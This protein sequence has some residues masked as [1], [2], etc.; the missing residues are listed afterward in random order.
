MITIQM[1][2]HIVVA[3]FSIFVF[4]LLGFVQRADAQ[5]YFKNAEIYDFQKH[6]FNQGLHFNF[7]T[8]REETRTEF[9]SEYNKLKSGEVKFQLSNR[10][11]NFM[12]YKQE[13]IDF[14]VE[15]GPLWGNGNWIDSS[16]VANIEADH[17]IF[18]VRLNASAGYSSRFYYNDKNYTLVQVKGWGRYDLYN[19][20]SNGFSVDSNN[21]FTGLNE[22]TTE[23]KFR[24]GVEAHAGWGI[25]RFKP[26]NNFMIADYLL[27]K[28]YNHRNFSQDEIL[29]FANE[30]GRI[31]SQRNIKTGHK[32]EVETAKM[33]EFLNQKMFL[34]PV[35]SLEE[36]WK[37][38][39]F[40]P[41]FNGN[42]VEFGPFFKYFNREPDFI[43]GGYFLYEHAK[44]CN[45]KWNRNFSA[46]VNYNAY[47]KQDWILG[48]VSMGWSYFIKLKS[49]IDFG[50]KYIPGIALNDAGETGSLNHGFIPYLGYFAQVDSKNR[51]DVK[52]AYRLSEDEN[53]M[54]SGPEISVAVYRSRY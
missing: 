47:K 25:G 3:T 20:N 35:N 36:E 2:K 39:E 19:Q 38:G 43:Y 7:N 45:V 53:L 24:Y 17:N 44:Y 12:D 33:Q 52:L 34:I 16:S 13:K 54:L 8:E 29:K 27:K 14:N 9:W 26:L 28:Y 10:F 32:T 41:R 23:N 18:G 42:R 5:Y 22:E 46:G 30:I 15:I 4:L 40:L 31:K 37:A 51:I 11:W 48:E 6:E 21:V 49:Q 50:V 1:K